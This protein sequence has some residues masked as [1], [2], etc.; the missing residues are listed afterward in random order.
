MTR[1][2]HFKGG[3]EMDKEADIYLSA[4]GIIR[5]TGDGAVEAC[6]ELVRRWQLRHE[7]LAALA[8]D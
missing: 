4:R 5:N 1:L 8:P 3:M 2:V 6:A 7:P